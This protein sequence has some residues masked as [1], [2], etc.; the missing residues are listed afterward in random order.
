[1]S[2][3]AAGEPAALRAAV[4]TPLRSFELALELE[5]R[6]GEPLALVGPSGAGKTSMLR[7][8]AG[9]LRPQRGTVALGAETWLDTER[10]RELPAERRRCG[11]VFQDYALFPRMSAWRNVAYGA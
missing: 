6:P 8:L 2:A 9:L 3:T 5:A 7:I 10:G 4:A 1:M 11:Y